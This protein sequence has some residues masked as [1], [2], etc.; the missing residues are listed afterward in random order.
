MAG[1]RAPHP[2]PRWLVRI[3]WG[4]HRSVYSVTRGRLGLRTHAPKQWGML[5]LT[6]VGRRTARKRGVILGYIED[7]PNLITPA[8]NGWFDPEPAWLL[9][10][11]TNPRAN[12]QSAQRSDTCGDRPRCR[13]GRA[14][15]AVAASG[16]FGNRSLHGCVCRDALPGNRDRHPPTRGIH[17]TPR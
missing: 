3:F 15:P 11:Q 10:L 16:R 1:K 6:T 14:A 5:R 7:G 2:F 17:L 8:M 13:P 12:G 4:V 9:N